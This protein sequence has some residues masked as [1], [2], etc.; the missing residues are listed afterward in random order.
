MN[1]HQ[2]MRAL[3]V[4][5][6]MLLSINPV[7]AQ[8][9]EDDFAVNFTDNI[10]NRGTSA[11][12]FLEIGIGAKAQ[13]IGGAFTALAN[14]ATALY[15]NPAGIASLE[16]ISITANHAAWLADT[17]LNYFG[18]VL[19]F[20]RGMAVGLI[21]NVLDYVDK[22]P[23]RTILQP[24]GTGEDYGAADLTLGMSYGIQLTNRFAFA[25]SGKYIQQK[26][27]NETA[28][29]FAL[30]FG[31]LYHTRLKGMSIGASITNFGGDMKLEGRDLVR[32]FDED[33]QNFSNDKLNVSLKT[34]AFPLPILFRFGLAYALELNSQ[35]KL[36]TAV[37]VIHPS[38]NIESMNLGL[39]YSF[40]N[41]FAL[42]AGY[43]SLF[44]QSRENGL[45]LG[46][47]IEASTKSSMGVGF[48]YAYSSWGLL[49]K[50][51]RFSIDL[52][53]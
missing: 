50:V 19:P 3:I 41:L 12:S 20:S 14:D 33:P 49:D 43:Q 21:L 42:R 52:S 6:F 2:I 35:N 18:I 44:D 9:G 16:S 51:Q 36:T 47:G 25:V 23:V 45:T 13:A 17:K 31:V 53:L 15:W 22:Q 48:N 38:N 24:E 32:A 7:S 46:F 8:T 5:T 29:T 40:M 27:W 39:E 34:D 10:T 26:I 30:D 11:A 37:D 4:G 1:I 28:K